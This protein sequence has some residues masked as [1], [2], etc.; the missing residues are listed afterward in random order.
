MFVNVSLP[1]LVNRQPERIL[2][3]YDVAWLSTSGAIEVHNLEIRQQSPKDQWLLHVDE[4]VGFVD[5]R[6]LLDRTIHVT[7]AEGRGVSFRWRARADATRRVTTPGVSAD[8][9]VAP[10]GGAPSEPFQVVADAPVEDWTPPIPGFTNP[11]VPSPEDIYPSATPWR[12]QLEGIHAESVRELWVGDYQYSGDG[13]LRGALTLEA[14]KWLEVQAVQLHLHDGTVTRG[15]E[16]M[17]KQ[18]AGDVSIDLVGTNPQALEGRDLFGQV[19]AKVALAADVANLAFLDFYLQS[20]P[21]L[22]LSGG[23]GTLAVDV[24]VEDGAFLDGSTVAADVHD[25]VARFLSYSV[26]GDGRVRLGVDTRDQVASTELSVDFLDFAIN[27]DGDEEPHVKGRGF[28]VSA[29]TADRALDRP[30]TTLDVVLELPE[31]EIP[32]VAV[33][34]AYLPRDLGLRLL[35]GAGVVKGHLEAS[36]GERKCHGVIDLHADG[37]RASLDGL[38]LSGDV[39]V[40]AEVPTGNLETGTYDISGTTLDLRRVRVV[41][42]D[43]N[44]GGKDNSEAWWAKIKLPTGHV[45]AGAP[46]FLDAGLAV[47][48]RDTVPFI[49]VFS[50]KQQLPGWVRGLL[51]VK[52]VTGT[53]RVQMGDDVLRVSRFQLFAGQFEVLLE[54]R[55]RQEMVGKLYA[56]YGK[57]SLGMALGA[58]GENT[59]R[60][61]NAK[62]WYDAQPKPD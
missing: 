39:A 57:L 24:A 2:M 42:A 23:V 7:A 61:F 3:T 54:L 60:L 35:A 59:F 20:A 43:S 34:D 26:V 5:L 58:R 1:I 18:V 25:I 38:T 9:A 51:A 13:E 45:A 48:F 15:P 53:A 4:G 41:S 33:Y 12:I 11:P 37:V 46:V 31:A 44:R 50:E 30:F 14:H 21:W 28:R 16:A 22:H 6:A 27:H 32:N 29:T 47:S 49:T 52:P 62:S 17:L 40:H 8:P 56:R 10:D 55:R 36:T 19:S